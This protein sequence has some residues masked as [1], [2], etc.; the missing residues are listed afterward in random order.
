MIVRHSEDLFGRVKMKTPFI[1]FFTNLFTNIKKQVD[2]VHC[3]YIHSGYKQVDY[4]NTN[5]PLKSIV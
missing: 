3:L 4:N 1:F 5:E 2:L